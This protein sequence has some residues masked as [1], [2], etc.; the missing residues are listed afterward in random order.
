MINKDLNFSGIYRATLYTGDKVYVPSIMEN[1]SNSALYPTALWNAPN[2]KATE[3]ELPASCWV[4][5][6]GGD[7]KRPVIMG[8][9]GDSIKMANFNS[10][11]EANGDN[12]F[13][14]GG[15]ISLTGNGDILLVA[16]HGNGDTGAAGCGYN[17]A[18]LTRD[19]VRILS[20]K[21]NCDVYDT[22]KN[23]YE[24][25]T[26]EAATQL[27]SKYKVVMEV[28][29]NSA[30]SPQSNGTEIL[31][32]NPSSPTN[33]ETLVLDALAST[34]IKKRSFKDGNW[35]G[36]LN[37]CKRAGVSNYFL[38]EV[39]FIINKGDMDNYIS[40]KDKI[41]T[42]VSNAFKQV[43]ESSKKQLNNPNGEKTVN[44]STS[45]MGVAVASYEQMYNYL[46]KNNPNAPDYIMTYLTEGAAEGVRGDIAFA[47]SCLETGF[48]RFG[49]DVSPYQNNFSGLGATGNGEPGNSFSTPQ[50]GILAQI[51]HLKLYAGD[52]NTNKP[53]VDQRHFES[54]KGK[55][56][57]LGSLTHNWATGSGYDGNIID[58]LNK[59]LAL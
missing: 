3:C 16:G 39:C 14:S 53:C 27:L 38:I 48:W 31:V 22:S 15:F 46:M 41:I 12:G 51:Q 37:K 40:N 25:L 49:G 24:D 29:F 36:N 33:I 44:S 42:A 18:D 34:G 55:A 8:F 17:E 32:A 54:I 26:G 47:Q 43:I 58:I 21:M 4:T 11:G 1:N 2:K 7:V 57:T 35:L 52:Y 19:F 30:D 28:H 6:E 10:S 45:I 20:S 13:G 5:F 59:I 9:M 50:E 56:T 23:M